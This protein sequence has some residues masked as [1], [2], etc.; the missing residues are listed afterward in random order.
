MK[1]SYSKIPSLILIPVFFFVTF[2]LKAQNFTKNDSVIAMYAT[3]PINID[4]VA[5]EPDWSLAAWYNIDVPWLVS[6]NNG[7]LRV[8]ND[9]GETW[10]ANDFS[11]RFKVLWSDQTNKIYFLVEILDNKLVKGATLT[12][13][14]W[15]YD[16]IEI[17][18]DE[19]GPCRTGNC[20]HQSN[21]TAYAYH[22]SAGTDTSN[23]D[24]FDVG[25]NEPYVMFNNV[26]NVVINQYEPNHYIWEMAMDLMDENEEI[27]TI[28]D[29][30]KIGF[31]IAYC[32]SDNQQNPKRELFAGSVYNAGSNKANLWMDASLFGGLSL[33][34][35]Q[36]TPINK[37]KL[38]SASYFN[39]YPNPCT[40]LVTI[41]ITQPN[42][43][44]L[45]L[46][47]ID[48]LGRKIEEQK[49]NG[50]SINMSLN[51]MP[52]GIY[53]IKLSGNNFSEIVRVQKTQN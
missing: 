21:N 1:N 39:V 36:P 37:N 20:N 14:Y 45:N 48:V 2:N 47:L 28:Y 25:V 15:E 22:V 23:F 31:A 11:G 49:F 8:A 29:G 43:G 12:N 50:K 53:Y 44:P 32:D 6:D 46:E 18:I 16:I 3:N 42:L 33:S 26:F 51:K 7:N 38:Q 40:D 27:T 5:E 13:N 35:E 4:G 30:K 19:D 41:K 17:F 34:T 24:V 10:D 52:Q 9:A